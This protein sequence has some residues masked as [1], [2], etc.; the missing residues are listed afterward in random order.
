MCLGSVLLVSGARG[1][2]E[3]KSP[4]TK[5]AE[6]KSGHVAKVTKPWSDIPSLTDEQKEKIKAVHEKALAE[7]NVLEKKEKSDIEALLTDAQKTEMADMKTK[8]KK[9]AAEKRAASKKATT[10][11]SEEKKAA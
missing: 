1:A 11:P 9:E 6:A 4:T 8:E 7:I 2:D 3:P 5:P 10:K